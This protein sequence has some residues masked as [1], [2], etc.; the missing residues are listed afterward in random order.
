MINSHHLLLE[1]GTE[2]LPPKLV[3]TLSQDL[4]QHF[5]AALKKHHLE[6][7][8]IKCFATPRRL[9][10]YV[11]DLADKQKDYITEKKGPSLKIIF[12]VNKQPSQAALGFAK[13]CNVALEDLIKNNVSPDFL[14][15]RQQVQ[16]EETKTLLPKI[17]SEALSALTF[18]RSMHWGDNHI[19][20]IRPVHWVVLLFGTKLIETTIL[21]KKSDRYTYGHR[22]HHPDA[23]RLDSS[24]EYETKLIDAF[25]IPDFNQRRNKIKDQIIQLAESISAKAAL[26]DDLLDENCGITEWPIALLAN[27]DK[28][29]LNVPHE[30]LITAMKFHQK[31]FYL[32]DEKTKQLLPHFIF[33]SNIKSQ[34]PEQVIAGNEKVMRARLS[35]AE[36]FY[37]NDCKQSLETFLN[38]LKGVIFQAKLGDLYQRANRLA[39]LSA[40]IA[41]EIHADTNLASQAGLLAKA[42]LMSDMV[43]E[44]PELQGIMGYYYATHEGLPTPVALAI[45]EHYNP[46]TANDILPTTDI[47]NAVALA[48]KIDKLVAIFAINQLPT[49]TKDP[50]G[51]RR[52]ALGIIR[53][54]ITQKYH[55]S[56]TFCINQA[57]QL[58]KDPLPNQ[59]VLPQ[60]QDFFLERLRAWY[61]E[62][63]ISPDI[64][65]AVAAKELDSL[66]DFHLRLQA[67]A[68]FRKLKESNN[69]AVANK[70]VNNILL[71][72]KIHSKIYTIEEQ[73]LTQDAEKELANCLKMKQEQLIP[74]IG[75][76]DYQSI[77]LELA[78]LQ[79]PVDRFFDE[80][81]VMVEDE[82][83]RYNRIAIL[84]ALRN[85]F[86]Q[87]ADISQLQGSI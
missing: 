74:L 26:D 87:V 9:S 86:L 56:L 32:F 46:Q 24:D 65:S 6:H 42:D 76:N 12:D 78:S 63:N 70:R 80:V 49:G 17:C 36:F 27:F 50:F 18:P 68:E 23:I 61:L 47:A 38:R 83:L 44:F 58:Y 55:L 48:D 29:F 19:E 64:F 85:L 71:K 13:S 10:V 25:V 40:C 51:L 53:I 35:D 39:D 8:E 41:K 1:I 59:N 14:V 43:N 57:L 52:C 60:L 54:C 75:K 77:L 73:F 30:A 72:E 3:K 62:Q 82:K 28:G 69:L 7:G 79:K 16:G 20:F 22:F 37:R 84:Q 15:Y 21:G 31:S 5:M 34:K 66:Y 4:C 33:V 81:M 11:M 67:V 2:E 45:K